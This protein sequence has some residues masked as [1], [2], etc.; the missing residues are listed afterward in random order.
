MK[1]LFLIL[2][3]LFSNVNAQ[4]ITISFKDQTLPVFLKTVYG[5][6]LK[7][8]YVIAPAIA[9]S[10]TRINLE[11]VFKDREDLISRLPSLLST[12]GVS[13]SLSG[14][15][16]M[17]NLSSS[18]SSN[19]FFPV[20][21]SLPSTLPAL[22]SPVSSAVSAP[23]PLPV[24]D[25]LLWHV[26][27]PSHRSPVFICSSLFP[28]VEEKTPVCTSSGS[29]VLLNLTKKAFDSLEPVLAAIDAPG[30][31]VEI[32]TALAEVNVTNSKG[33]GLRVVASIFGASLEFGTPSVTGSALTFKAPNFSFLLD[34]LQ[35][36]Q[37]VVHVVSP[38]G[39]VDSGQKLNLSIGDRQPTLS[40]IATAGTG[41][42]QQSITY[43]T[44]GAILAVTPTVFADSLIQLA[45]DSEV[46][47]FSPT[48]TG[49]TQSPT[50]SQ[51]KVQTNLTLKTGQ[52]VVL[53]GLR[54][55]KD[56]GTQNRLFG[57]SA[58]SSTASQTTDLVLLVHAK[59]VQ[60]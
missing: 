36:D 22:P 16:Y 45:I 51:R 54:S 27:K 17:L 25:P 6:I 2:A 30:Q 46:S 12:L 26:F 20:S 58:G 24:A 32:S 47:T 38:S 37:R 11:L 5:D 3:F 4:P 43:Q 8:G 50:I 14:S 33:S 40:A 9:S 29:S 15:A 23:L 56:S 10:S 60:E 19:P 31:R 42:S 21:P 41:L 48:T 28:A 49:L 13:S 52:V 7:S 1:K 57:W 59:I 35:T 34:A 53:G 44:A 39:V 55:A 18:Q